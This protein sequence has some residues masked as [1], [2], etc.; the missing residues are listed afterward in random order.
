MKEKDVCE[1]NKGSMRK[2]LHSEIL[3]SQH[4]SLLKSLSHPSG[5]D[6]REKR[7]RYERKTERKERRNNQI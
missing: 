6:I 1:K 3:A 2:V 7:N 5:L 4:H